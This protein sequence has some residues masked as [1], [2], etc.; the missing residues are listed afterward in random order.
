M[1]NICGEHGKCVNLYYK[2][3]CDCSVGLFWEGKYCEKC[4]NILYFLILEKFFNLK[5]KLSKF[6]GYSNY[7]SNWY[8]IYFSN[9]NILSNKY[10]S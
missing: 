3:Y 8:H 2:S 5:K 9:I 6:C 10:F 4:K 1:N 7:Y